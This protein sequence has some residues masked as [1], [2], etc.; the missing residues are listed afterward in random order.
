[1]TTTPPPVAVRIASTEDLLGIVPSLLG[2]HPGE[3]LVLILVCAGR[4][5][6]TARGDLAELTDY[7]RLEDSFGLVLDRFPGAE[8]F[9]IAYTPDP[10][11][12]WRVLDD[13][14]RL[15]LSWARRVHVDGQRWY[16]A[17]GGPGQP[18]DPSATASAAAATFAGIT[19]RG[20]RP[21]RLAALEGTYREEDRIRAATRV[22]AEAVTPAE[23]AARADAV[24]REFLT[25]PETEGAALSLAD[26]VLL[27]ADVVDGDAREAR[28]L[29]LS[30]DTSV[31]MVALWSQV[32]QG[33]PQALAGGA[34]TMLAV[35]AWVQGDGALARL[36]LEQLLRLDEFDPWAEFVGLACD[37][38]VNPECWDRI[39][40]DYLLVSGRVPI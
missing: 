25:R 34:W 17:P 39:R 37:Q 6:V 10:V 24:A 38:A 13:V 19:V 21:E 32:V 28:I 26:R 18:Y 33:A 2:F 4:L 9:A 31:R 20:S 1:M 35:S 7:A 40:A 30:R 8:V 27:A 29:G 14:G 23:L 11:A 12:G 16:E 5:E 36:C 15:T 22:L 3:S